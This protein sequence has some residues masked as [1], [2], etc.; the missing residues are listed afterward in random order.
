MVMGCCCG[1]VSTSQERGWVLA[2]T[3]ATATRS[4]IERATTTEKYERASEFVD[5]KTVEL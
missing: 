5:G 2:A 3:E 4:E 1:Q